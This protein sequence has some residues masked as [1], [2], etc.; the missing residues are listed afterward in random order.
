MDMY[1][2]LPRKYINARKTDQERFHALTYEEMRQNAMPHKARRR[3]LNQL[4]IK[5]IRDIFEAVRI[6]KLTHASTAIKFSVTTTTVRN[7]VRNFRVKDDYVQELL[8][9]Q[10]SRETKI[11][12][13]LR[14]IQSFKDANKDIWSL[15]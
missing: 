15:K 3:Q 9:K 6:D 10:L 12:T 11:T 1:T 4:S 2:Q 5:E 14:A 8:D 13:V 7:I